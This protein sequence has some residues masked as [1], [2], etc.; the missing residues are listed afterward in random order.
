MEW[1]EQNLASDHPYIP[2]VSKQAIA[3][4][5]HQKHKLS[6]SK[7]YTV[8][9]CY[10]PSDKTLAKFFAKRLKSYLPCPIIR[11]P[12]DSARGNTLIDEA[13][14][15]VLFLS[16]SFL[17]SAELTEQANIALCRQRASDRLVMLSVILAYLPK[18]PA[19]FR[20]F[21]CFFS[22]TD[23]MWMDR[24]LSVKERLVWSCTLKASNAACLDSAA[25]FAGF[26]VSNPDI[27]RG[28]F[29]TF[30]NL[31]E[32][33]TSICSLQESSGDVCFD[34]N[35]LKFEET[36]LPP[37]GN[38]ATNAKHAGSTEIF[39][40]TSMQPSSQQQVG[41]EPTE[42]PS[43]SSS[44]ESSDADRVLQVASVDADT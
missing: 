31:L 34:T 37:P 7:S 18:I 10:H 17:S 30:L 16:P 32:L 40:A 42:T 20:L 6:I 9:L 12:E 43:A 22:C 41:S 35:P 4:F 15:V 29:K 27:F 39:P 13:D 24:Q 38:Y 3:E 19:Y 28:S 36:H 1:R 14:L 33:K 2:M 8:V 5:Y 11:R 21:T 44:H 26:L 25:S 23:E